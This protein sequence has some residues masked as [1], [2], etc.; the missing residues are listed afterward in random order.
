MSEIRR[1]AFEC[2][3]GIV[4]RTKVAVPR[5]LRN[6][7]AGREQPGPVDETCLDRA[8]EIGVRAACI[9]NSREARVE[10]VLRHCSRGRAG[11]RRVV[12]LHAAGVLAGKVRVQVDESGRQHAI[13]AVDYP[14]IVRCVNPISR[15][16]VDD[17]VDDQDVAGLE[18]VVDAVEDPDVFDQHRLR[19]GG[20]GNKADQYGQ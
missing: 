12:L 6:N 9:A 1:S 7:R 10:V 18:S 2:R 8:R 5:C 3:V 17:T 11:N 20:G 13:I 16:S 4:W 15:D 19:I 14:G